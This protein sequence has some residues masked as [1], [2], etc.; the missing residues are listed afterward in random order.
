MD[1]N[2][3]TVLIASVDSADFAMLFS[4]FF[5]AS[6]CMSFSSLYTLNRGGLAFC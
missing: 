5:F 2:A 4:H 6:Q 3:I 1:V